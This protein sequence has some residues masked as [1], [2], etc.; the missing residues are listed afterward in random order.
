MTLSLHFRFAHEDAWHNAELARFVSSLSPGAEL[1]LCENASKADVIIAFTSTPSCFPPGKWKLTAEQRALRTQTP[2]VLVWDS[3]DHPTGSLAGL[4]CSL[5][6]RLFD[7]RRHHTS[8][9]PICYN[10]TV[11]HFPQNEASTLLGFHGGPSAPVRLRLLDLLRREMRP[12][13]T[14]LVLQEGPWSRM[15]DRTGVPEKNAYA[16]T[17]RNTRFFICPKGNG[18]GSIRLFETMKAG[19]VPVIISD[20]YVLPPG[21]DWESCSLRV[22]EK[23]LHTLPS[24]V[25]KHQEQWPRMAVA[26]RQVWEQQFSPEGFLPALTPFLKAF[27]ADPKLRE[28]S[29]RHSSRLAVHLAR[30]RL[31]LKA[32]LLL[33]KLRGRA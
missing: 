29:H 8:C 16:A 1:R 4:Y 33:A 22:S 31:R 2:P 18:V 7:P 9:Y 6:R 20:D 24:L 14:R 10:E 12:E 28:P 25:R 23:Q 21:I 30:S 3:G 26:A 13:E 17:L 5:P 19:R 11:E 32:G 15:F 27:V